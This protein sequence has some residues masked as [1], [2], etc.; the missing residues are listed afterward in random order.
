MKERTKTII[1]ISLFAIFLVAVV[2]SYKKLA[3]IIFPREVGEAGWEKAPDF[4][5]QDGDG[6]EVKLSDF[7]G[8][9]VVLN[10]WASWCPPCRSEMPEFD[11]AYREAGDDVAFLMVNMTDGRRETFDSASGFIS[12]Q[13]YTFPVYYDTQLSAATAYGI[14]AIPVTVF[15]DSEGRIAKTEKGAISADRLRE[16]IELIT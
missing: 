14:S 4:T 8:R 11:D 5:V 9:P 15:I 6:N 1:L 2:F 10:F 16:G 7:S 12:E 13:G 3:A